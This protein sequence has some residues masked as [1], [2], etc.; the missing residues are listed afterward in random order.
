MRAGT[1]G[2]QLGL[3]LPMDEK[4]GVRVSA[5]EMTHQGP[6]TNKPSS[7]LNLESQIEPKWFLPG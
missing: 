2:A 6:G 4:P 7:L 1:V 3:E 5:A